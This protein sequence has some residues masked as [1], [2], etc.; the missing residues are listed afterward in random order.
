MI[1]YIK[2]SKELVKELR[3]YIG[4]RH[5]RNIFLI[6]SVTANKLRLYETLMNES[7]NRAVNNPDRFCN[8]RQKVKLSELF[9]TA[10]K[11]PSHKRTLKSIKFEY[12]KNKS[13]R[14]PSLTSIWKNLNLKLNFNYKPTVQKPKSFYKECRVKSEILFIYMLFKDIEAKKRIVFF[15]EAGIQEG[16]KRK[17]AW[18]HKGEDNYTKANIKFRKLNLLMLNSKWKI[19]RYVIRKKATDSKAVINFFKDYYKKIGKI[20]SSNT[21]VVLDNASYHCSRSVLREIPKHFNRFLFIPPNMPI[22]NEIEYLFCIIKKKLK[23]R[24]DNDK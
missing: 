12:L 19:D 17:K 8:K 16:I 3:I 15:D 24:E 1:K 20:Q 9:K 10:I 5:E 22:Y 14:T 7:A 21:T 23:W 2:S 18:K 4:D 13:L 6:P 11:I